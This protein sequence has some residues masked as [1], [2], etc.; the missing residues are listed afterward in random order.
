MS[1]IK[2]REVYYDLE[3]EQIAILHDLCS[4]WQETNWKILALKIEQFKHAPDRISSEEIIADKLN[5]KSRFF[6]QNE[7]LPSDTMMSEPK[8]TKETEVS[9]S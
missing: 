1:K 4:K 2:I 5:V 9:K 3:E 6:C 8:N 7:K